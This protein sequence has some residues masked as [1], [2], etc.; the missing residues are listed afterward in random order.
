MSSTN[1]HANDALAGASRHI[2]GIS[3]NG[4]LAVSLVAVSLVCIVVI[5]GTFAVLASALTGS[6]HDG[7]PKEVID[8]LVAKHDVKTDEYATRFNERYIFY[9][10]PPKPAPPRPVVDTPPPPPP[11]VVDTTPKA[12]ATYQGPSIAWVIGDDVYFN[13]VPATTTEK[14]MRLRVGE[15]RNGLKV[16]NTENLP[17]TVHVAHMGGEYDVKV[18]GDG[19]STNTLFP[20]TPRPSIL[21]PGF[22]PAGEPA[23]PVTEPAT[24][25][26]EGVEGDGGTPEANTESG[27]GTQLHAAPADGRGQPQSGGR[28]RGR[29]SRGE[30]RER[31]QRPSENPDGAGANAAEDD[32]QPVTSKDGTPTTAR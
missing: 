11:P 18:F 5:V 8:D 30:G 4:S 24:A 10:P 1:P 3:F 26:A 13:L 7:L 6:I 15:E 17:R 21:V 32:P 2:A 27:A 14:Y 19:M 31:P 22:I 12:P 16:L 25:D 29:G 20:T 23:P 9:K 28:S